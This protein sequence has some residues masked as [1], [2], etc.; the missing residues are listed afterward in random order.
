MSV[1]DGRAPLMIRAEE[2]LNI[3]WLSH[4]ICENDDFA[5]MTAIKTITGTL[6]SCLPNKKML[7]AMDKKV[8]IIKDYPI[9]TRDCVKIAEVV[10]SIDNQKLKALTEKTSQEEILAELH[11]LAEFAEKIEEEENIKKYEFMDLIKE[12]FEHSK[13]RQISALERIKDSQIREIEQ[14]DHNQ[15][16][17]TKI[18]NFRD[19]KERD[20]DE[21]STV[22]SEINSRVVTKAEYFF[23][24][25]SILIG[26]VLVVG[27]FTI[28]GIIYLNW[29]I[30]E[31]LLYLLAFIPFALSYF[32]AA[33]YSQ[34]IFL[35]KILSI[36]KTRIKSHYQKR[37]MLLYSRK[38]KLVKRIEN[39]SEN[40]KRLSKEMLY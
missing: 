22:I 29:A 31:P 13:E 37:N 1:L 8:Q 17:L 21:L 7:K 4:P 27:F 12:K 33:I 11:R 16:V 26:V 30:A 38:E 34:E 35:L 2:L 9:N 19:L 39:S 32:F 3:M 24:V 40:I 10:A 15:L 14:E 5:R 20:E 36:L 18:D 6:N 23:R 25:I 28:A